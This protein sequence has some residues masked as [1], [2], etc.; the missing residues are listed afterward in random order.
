MIVQKRKIVKNIEEIKASTLLEQ[1]ERAQ[2]LA[3][4]RI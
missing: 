2:M 3:E 1:G 4:E